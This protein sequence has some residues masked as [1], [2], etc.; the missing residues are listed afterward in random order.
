MIPFYIDSAQKAAKLASIC[1]R[2]KD[3]IGGV[4]VHYGKY[5]ID[6]AS[7]MGL[8]DLIGRFV[9]L[10]VINPEGDKFEM[11]KTEV[12]EISGC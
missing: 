3:N 5:V 1:D 4:D 10:E 8:V 11:F 12:E 9:G 7:V 6:G 2:Y